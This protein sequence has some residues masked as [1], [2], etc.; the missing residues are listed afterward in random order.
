MISCKTERLRSGLTRRPRGLVSVTMLI[1]LIILGIVAASL[2]K[3]A[4]GRRGLAHTEEAQR[5]AELVLEAGIDR[6]TARLAANPQYAGEVWSIP[7]T[8]LGRGSAEVTIQLEPMPDPAAGRRLLVRAD[9]R[10]SAQQSFRLSRTILWP[11]SPTA[12]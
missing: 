2:L 11:L 3:V 10:V 8:E 1:G 7:V 6:A 4:L 12:R 9:Y 5:Q